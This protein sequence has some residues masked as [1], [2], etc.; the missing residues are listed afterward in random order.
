[1]ILN[2]DKKWLFVHVPKAAGTSIKHFLESSSPEAK[3]ENF[4]LDCMRGQYRTLNK[5]IASHKNK[6][7]FDSYFKFAFVRN[8]WDRAVSAYY[9]I[10]KIMKGGYIQPHSMPNYPKG[11]TFKDLIK[12]HHSLNHEVIWHYGLTQSDILCGDN[13]NLLVD[14]V[15]RFESL[16]EDLNIICDKIGIPQQKLPH[17]NKSNHKHYSDYYDDEAR[18]IVAEKYAKDIEN[19]GYKFGE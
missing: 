5:T 11:I 1:M 12:K 6:Y 17:K 4:N 19:F 13:G 7:P 14:F 9:Y 18:E 2:P 8:P 16:Q 15:G 3:T 10:L